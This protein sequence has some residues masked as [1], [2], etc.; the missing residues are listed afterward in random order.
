ILWIIPLVGYTVSLIIRNFL[1]SLSYNEEWFFQYLTF[2]Y[3]PLLYIWLKDAKI[4]FT[5][6]PYLIISIIAFIFVDIEGNILF[7]P[8]IRHLIHKNDL[9]IGHAH[10]AMGIGVAFMSLSILH[11]ILPNLFSKYFAMLWGIALG[12]M[13][14]VLTIAGIKEAGLFEMNINYLWMIRSLFGLLV[15]IYIFS[16]SIKNLGLKLESKISFYHLAGLLSDGIGGLLL[17]LAGNVIFTTLGFTFEDSFTYAVFAFMTGVGM[18]HFFG[19]FYQSEL[20]A[21]IA[22]LIRVLVGSMFIALFVTKHIDAIGLLVGTYDI[23]FALI[24]LLYI[25]VENEPIHHTT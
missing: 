23:A 12:L 16:I 14:L 11:N 3:I 6:N 8:E 24:Y 20:L 13:T 9:V 10:I 25:K 4:N 1:H 2:F 19:L 5:T 15:I 17:I 21:H 22:A 18:V 7:V